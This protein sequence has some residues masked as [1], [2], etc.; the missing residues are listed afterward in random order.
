MLLH[1]D[2]AAEDG[3]VP[4]SGQLLGSR[5]LVLWPSGLEDWLEGSGDRVGSVLTHINMVAVRMG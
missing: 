5:G 4:L 1:A 2:H 3:K